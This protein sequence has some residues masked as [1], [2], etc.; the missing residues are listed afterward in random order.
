MA[1]IGSLLGP[2]RV[3]HLFYDKMVMPEGLSLEPQVVFVTRDGGPSHRSPR[4]LEEASL[5]PVQGFFLSTLSAANRCSTPFW[6]EHCQGSDRGSLR[7][8]R[9]LALVALAG[10][11]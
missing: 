4:E 7:P 8:L 1:D 9:F 5:T 11:A 3:C 2:Q 10:F 6:V